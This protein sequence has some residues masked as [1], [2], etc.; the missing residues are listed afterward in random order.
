MH[1][2]LLY[3]LHYCTDNNLGAIRDSINIDFNRL[4]K[5]SIKQDR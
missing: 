5:I 2:R 3:V 1:T 4:I